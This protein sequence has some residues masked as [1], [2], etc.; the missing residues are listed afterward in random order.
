MMTMTTALRAWRSWRARLLALLALVLSVGVAWPSAAAPSAQAQP[1]WSDP[2][3]LFSSTTRVTAPRLVADPSGDV[4]LFFVH[5][6]ASGP[7]DHSIE[8]RGAGRL[9]ENA[10][11]TS[12]AAAA[13]PA[14]L[15]YMRLHD[16][17]W[18]EPIDVLV[19]PDRGGLDSPAVAL[20]A[21]GFLHVTWQGGAGADIYY[22]S[23]HVSQAGTAR[24]WSQPQ[25][26]SEGAGG[27]GSDI[28]AA[29][30]GTL[31]VVYA[32]RGG[33]V[34]SR[35]SADAG[36]TWSPRVTVSE[37]PRG[38]RATDY[39]RIAIDGRGRLHVVW[40]E[41][42]LP[43]GWPPLG[44]FYSRSEDGGQTWSNALPV[45]G[46]QYG[47]VAVAV[48][49]LDHV[50]LVWNGSVAVGDR[51]FQESHDGGK[52]WSAAQVVS[53]SIRGGFVGFP[54][55]SFDSA[56]AL[57]VVTSVDL[58]RPEGQ[59]GPVQAVYHL[60]WDGATWSAPTLISNGVVGK[61]SVEHPWIAISEGNRL[62][63]VWEDDFQRIWYTS[64]RSPAP[65]LSVQAVPAPPARVQPT[66]PVRAQPT[67]AATREA[68]QWSAGP[69][70]SSASLPIREPFMLSVAPVLVLIA[71]AALARLVRR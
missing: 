19:S 45:A 58:P 59:Q 3:L 17:R 11:P 64:G 54:G 27:F 8:P 52:A 39:P 7:D 44:A 42:E 53:A 71:T 12:T 14:V 60:S 35:R 62:Q 65:A 61:W 30:D 33:D 25:V 32:E 49:G 46:L 23:A 29:P 56:G 66:R 22:S 63:V 21:R 5:S 51:R 41:L 2:V 24:G 18:T 15:M 1:A 40:T 13:Q 20:D 37:I 26:L 48:R 70:P 43:Q 16:G 38:Q 55:L 34:F 28:A 69:A 68:A 9:V 10:P 36:R 6:G 50:G 47:Q 57:H 4:H 67:P 31:H